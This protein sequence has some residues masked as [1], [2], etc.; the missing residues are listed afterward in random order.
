VIHF[1]LDLV[2]MVEEL[3]M[4]FF[5]DLLLVVV[6]MIVMVLIVV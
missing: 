6:E 5:V 4:D 3:V 1:F 2:K